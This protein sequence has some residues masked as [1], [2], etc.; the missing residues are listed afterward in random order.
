M[1][2]TSERQEGPTPRGGAYTIA[3]WKDADGEATTKAHATGVEIVEF[4]KQDSVIAR[5]YA[6]IGEEVPS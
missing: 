3:Y 4:D 5:T 2:A 1:P 6:T